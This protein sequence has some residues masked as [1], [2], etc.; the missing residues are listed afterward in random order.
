MQPGQP[1]QQID[2]RQLEQAIK[3]GKRRMEVLSKRI[4][5]KLDMRVALG[6]SSASSDLRN[7]I[8]SQVVDSY[9]NILASESTELEDAYKEVEFQVGQMEALHAQMKS[10]I[11]IPQVQVRRSN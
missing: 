7:L 8:G 3:N 10:N 5:A 1:V 2:I 11:I 4:D 9:I 6:D